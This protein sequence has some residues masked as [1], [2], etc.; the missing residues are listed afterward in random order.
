MHLLINSQHL[1][2]YQA[3]L[4]WQIKNF[5]IL[6]ALK[7]HLHI[8]KVLCFGKVGEVLNHKLFGTSEEG[9]WAVGLSEGEEGQA[10]TKIHGSYQEVAAC[11]GQDWD[12]RTQKWKVQDRNIHVKA[13]KIYTISVLMQRDIVIVHKV[14]SRQDKWR[15]LFRCVADILTCHSKKSTCV[16]SNNINAVS[17]LFCDCVTSDMNKIS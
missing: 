6:S 1:S 5:F 16:A 12:L 14:V 13:Q 7:Q 15:R 2:L 10:V 8:Q 4:F 11:S 9:G 3:Q 17:V